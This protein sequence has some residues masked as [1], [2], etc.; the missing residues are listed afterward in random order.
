MH[1]TEMNR[2]KKEIK[3]RRF[4]FSFLKFHIFFSLKFLKQ[5]KMRRKKRKV[6]LRE[7]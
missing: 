1:A 6:K 7:Q 5:I 3:Q 2:E 4:Y